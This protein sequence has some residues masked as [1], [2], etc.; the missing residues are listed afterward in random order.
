MPYRVCTP[1]P[2]MSIISHAGRRYHIITDRTAEPAFERQQHAGRHA[3]GAGDAAERRLRLRR[4]AADGRSFLISFAG[5]RASQASSP[6]YFHCLSKIN[7][8]TQVLYNIFMPDYHFTRRFIACLLISSRYTSRA[9]LIGFH[10]PSSHLLL[11]I[12]L[13]T[14]RFYFY[15]L[16]KNVI[17]VTSSFLMPLYFSATILFLIRH[18]IFADINLFSLTAD[19]PPQKYIDA[20]GFRYYSTTKY[21]SFSRL[22]SEFRFPRLLYLLHISIQ[23]CREFAPPPSYA[24]TPSRKR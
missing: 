9:T 8:M 6:H 20:F 22:L 10:Q 15:F 19:A 16:Y 3:G 11:Y 24:S 12:T 18:D 17:M 14:R 7:K 21:A 13:F 2:P 4:H 5:L 1:G 23:P